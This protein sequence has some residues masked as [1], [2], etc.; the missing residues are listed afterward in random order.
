MKKHQIQSFT[1]G[2]FIGNFDPSLMRVKEFEAAMKFYKKGDLEVAHFHRVAIEFTIIGQG[3]FR[4]ND[5]ILGPGDI[6][7][8]APGE[9]SDFE[10]MENGVTFVIKSPSAPD[11]KFVIAP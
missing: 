3:K 7:E 8:L 9:T 2:W 10:C 5:N 6:I 11:D 1:K 4:M